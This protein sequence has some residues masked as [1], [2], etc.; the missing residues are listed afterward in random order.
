MLEEEPKT[1][2]IFDPK[3]EMDEFYFKNQLQKMRDINKKI[4]KNLMFEFDEVFPPNVN[5]QQVFNSTVKSV[6]ASILEGF[7]CSG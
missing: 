1:M 2:L 6:I 7:N 4:K 5:N 3:V